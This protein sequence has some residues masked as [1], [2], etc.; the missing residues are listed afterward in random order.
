MATSFATTNVAFGIP[1]TGLL[2]STRDITTQSTSTELAA[3]FGY[4]FVVR[5]LLSN[6]K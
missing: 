6:E 2:S 4:K 3:V 1:V 5:L